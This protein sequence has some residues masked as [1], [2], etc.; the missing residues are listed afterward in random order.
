[1][2]IWQPRVGSFICHPNLNTAVPLTKPVKS[3]FCKTKKNAEKGFDTYYQ[4]SHE[5]VHRGLCRK[6]KSL[7]Y[8]CL[9]LGL[10]P[11][12]FFILFNQNTCPKLDLTGIIPI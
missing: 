12:Y 8:I 3:T 11:I 9:N 1:M 4:T 10:M 7:I 6:Y 2:F 5:S